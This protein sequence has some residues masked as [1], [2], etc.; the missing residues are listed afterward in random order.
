MDTSETYIKMCDH[1]AIQ[2]LRIL[3]QYHRDRR[4]QDRED[5]LQDGDFVCDGERVLVYGGD[6]VSICRIGDMCDIGTAGLCEGAG[7]AVEKVVWLPR[8]DQL[9]AM[10]AGERTPHQLSSDFQSW[11]TSHAPERRQYAEQFTSM[12]QLWLGFVMHENHGKAWRAG[13]WVARSA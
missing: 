3:S 13:T 8:Q 9:Q 10:V 6:K 11:H 1:P 12:E 5:S 7:Y 2:G 4:E